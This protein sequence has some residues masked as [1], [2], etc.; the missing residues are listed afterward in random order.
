MFISYAVLM[1]MLM[2]SYRSDDFIQE[3][4]K[5]AA[6]LPGPHLYLA[7]HPLATHSGAAL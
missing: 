5:A 1:C 4:C 3:A 2:C 7:Q 6:G